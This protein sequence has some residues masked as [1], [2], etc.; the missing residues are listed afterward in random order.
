VCTVPIKREDE[1]NTRITVLEHHEW[2]F[3]RVRTPR[4]TIM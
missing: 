1:G 2:M 3:S 4:I